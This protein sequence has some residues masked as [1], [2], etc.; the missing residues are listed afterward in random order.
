MAAD[1]ARAAD[2]RGWLRRA[3]ADLRSAAVEGVPVTPLRLP[4]STSPC[5]AAR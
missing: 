1:A 2:T 5:A 4:S 3:A